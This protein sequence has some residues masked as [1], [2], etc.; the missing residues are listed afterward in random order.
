MDQ[1]K[2]PI[3]TIVYVIIAIIVIVAVYFAITQKTQSPAPGSD[4]LQVQPGG[5]TTTAIQ[6]DLDSID[7]GDLDAEL[8]N[9]DDQLNDL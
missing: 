1:T 6:N 9:I 3:K 7:T 5:D 8:K 4:S 2:S